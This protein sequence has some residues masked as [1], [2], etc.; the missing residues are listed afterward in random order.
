MHSCPQ[1]RRDDLHAS[2]SEVL[3]QNA[4]KVAKLK[5]QENQGENG[6]VRCCA[7]IFAMR[8]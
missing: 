2:G 3:R 5:Q 6:S 4:R 1:A 7:D 8:F